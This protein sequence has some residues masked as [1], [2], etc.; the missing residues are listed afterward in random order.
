[1]GGRRGVVDPYG[2]QLARLCGTSE[3]HRRVAAR[4]PAEERR[5]GAARA[6][7]EHLLD[8]PDPLAVSACGDALD[9]LDQ[10][11]DALALDL[12][13]HLVGE[14]CGFR[15]AAGRED[16]RERAVVAD[17]VHGL[18]RLREV[19]LGLA[20]KAYDQVGREREIWD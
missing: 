20:R 10:A 4:A 15:T 13:R 14:R 18:E 8:P 2:G 7:D 5:V 12:F 6:L 11:L 17:L 19:P 3:V 9:D 16:E 1:G